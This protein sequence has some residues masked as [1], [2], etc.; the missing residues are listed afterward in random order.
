LYQTYQKFQTHELILTLSSSCC[1]VKIHQLYRQTIQ[2][3]ATNSE[4][5]SA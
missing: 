4:T 5:V 1:K 3:T 2:K